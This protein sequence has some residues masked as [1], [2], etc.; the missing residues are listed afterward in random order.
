ML[1]FGVSTN[2]E[3]G[4]F[5]FGVGVLFALIVVLALYYLARGAWIAIRNR[6]GD[7][8]W[9]RR[10]RRDLSARLGVTMLKVIGGAVAFVLA[11]AGLK[12]V[13]GL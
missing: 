8:S 4:S 1:R 10:F 3:R 12:L 11:G 7:E 6:Q 9:G 13:P 2:T 5:L